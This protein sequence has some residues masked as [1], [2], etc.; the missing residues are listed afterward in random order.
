MNPPTW[1]DLLAN[2]ALMA[3]AAKALQDYIDKHNAALEDTKH[4]DGCF[5]CIKPCGRTIPQTPKTTR[6]E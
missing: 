1:A 4:C 6:R 2:E 5:S 3:K